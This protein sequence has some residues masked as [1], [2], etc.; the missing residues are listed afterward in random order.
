VRR[1]LCELFGRGFVADEL[2]V[3]EQAQASSSSPRFAPA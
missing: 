1:Q 3:F 2:V